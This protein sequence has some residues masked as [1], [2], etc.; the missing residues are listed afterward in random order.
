MSDDLRAALAAIA[1][2]TDATPGDRLR[3]LERLGELAPVH[4]EDEGRLAIRRHVEALSDD[5][6]DQELDAF[7]GPEVVEE[8]LRG[9][10]GNFPRLAEA[11]RSA[12][13]REAARLAD[14]ERIDREIEERA[15]ARARE[16]YEARAFR[17]VETPEEAQGDDG[18]G[19]PAEG[20]SGREDRP[21]RL[22]GGWNLDR[23]W[24]E[25]RP[26]PFRRP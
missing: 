7:F 3:A 6:L 18:A 21:R 1:Y 10:D 5:A 25:D 22:P 8:A 11:I 13:G 9:E 17:A 14:A 16:L 26:S 19:E 20:A 2:G 15:E 23:G 24:P 4:P 12:I